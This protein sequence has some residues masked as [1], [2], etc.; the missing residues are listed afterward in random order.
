MT[1]THKSLAAAV[2]LTATALCC[3]SVKAR[4]VEEAFT[5]MPNHLVPMLTS[6]MRLDM[7]DYYRAGS[8]RPTR[9][10]L[11]D[12][13]RVVYAD[14]SRMEVALSPLSRMELALVPVKKDTLLA[15]IETVSTP[16]EDSFV[17]FYTSDWQHV[18]GPLQPLAAD[19]ALT[20]SAP[21][22][23]QFFVSATYVPGSCEFVFTNTTSDS[24]MVRLAPEVYGA[25]GAERRYRFDGRKLVPTDGRK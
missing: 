12:S 5:S 14:D 18:A 8:S 9:N 7:V 13:S 16:A 4:T 3:L 19:F 10:V 11:Y 22:L 20:P 2:I 15:V 25:Y 23:P 21:V 1:I 17:N 6:N 24:V